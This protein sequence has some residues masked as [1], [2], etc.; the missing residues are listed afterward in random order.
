MNLPMNL[1]PMNLTT[2]TRGWLVSVPF[3][4]A[5]TDEALAMLAQRV[6]ERR[7]RA[8]EIVFLEG[9]A[10]AGLHM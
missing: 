5:L 6:V 2:E 3:F 1:T 9:E 4:A 10:F 7:S 8:G